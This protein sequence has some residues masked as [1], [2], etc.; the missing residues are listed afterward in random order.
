MKRVIS[1]DGVP[2][3]NPCFSSDEFNIDDFVGER[4]LAIDGSSILFVQA[5]GS[6]TLEVQVSS[7]SSGWVTKETKDLLVTTVDNLVKVVE[8]DDLSTD[9]FYYDHT[10]IPLQIEPLFEGCLWYN[11]EINLL[12]G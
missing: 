2:L 3:D 4:T 11:V 12:K 5:K 7:K 8:Y 6:M 1:I 10:K 9:N